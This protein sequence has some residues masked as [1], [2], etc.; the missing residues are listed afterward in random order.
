MFSKTGITLD[1]PK[2]TSSGG[3]I[4]GVFGGVKGTTGDMSFLLGTLK[5][6][7]RID[8]VFDNASSRAAI[9]FGDLGL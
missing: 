2:P 3:G 7:D 9:N 1:N 8:A 6:F 4:A 5:D